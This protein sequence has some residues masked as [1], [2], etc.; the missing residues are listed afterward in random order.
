MFKNRK[1]LIIFVIGFITFFVSAN[2][3]V[4]AQTTTSG[5]SDQY[6]ALQDKIKELEANASVFAARSEKLKV[7]RVSIKINLFIPK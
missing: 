2:S 6:N 1:Y 3:F 5:N 7:L 4:S